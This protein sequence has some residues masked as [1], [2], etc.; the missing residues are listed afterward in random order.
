MDT[1]D[2]KIYT[3]TVQVRTG[4]VEGVP[5][6]KADTE[7]DYGYFEFATKLME[8]AEDW[9]QL[10]PYRFGAVSDGPFHVYKTMMNGQELSLTSDYGQSFEIEPGDYELTV[11]MENMTLKINGTTLTSI[12]ELNINNAAKSGRFN[13]MGQPVDENYKG[14]VIENGV[15]K[16]QK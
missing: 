12:E 5:G 14:I 4:D 10:A 8:G 11:D 7:I 13:L 6:L 2:G 9:D 3:K 1:E 15:K 16:I